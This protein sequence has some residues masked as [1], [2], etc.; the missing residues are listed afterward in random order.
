MAH[1]NLP[2]GH[3]ATLRGERLPVVGKRSHRGRRILLTFGALVLVVGILYLA[4]GAYIALK[5]SA[6]DPMA[7]RAGPQVFSLAYES[8]A[9]KARDGISL[10]SW[11]M[12]REGSDRAL[13][14]VHGLWTCRSCEFD[15]RFVELASHLHDAGYNIL[16]I[17]LRK[18]GQSGG[19]HVTYGQNE[20]LDVLAAVDWLKQRGFN[21]IGVVGVS[22]GGGSAV[23]AAAD[24]QGGDSIHALVLDSVFSNWVETMD[25]SFTVETGLPSQLLPGAILMMRVLM[26]VDLYAIRPVDKLPNIKAPVMMIYGGQDKYLTRAQMDAMHQARPDAEFWFVPEAGHTRIYNIREQEYVTRVTRF[27]DSALR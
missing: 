6:P 24:P 7:A 18:H 17:D 11:F 5:L 16:M 2:I 9:I 21:K 15:G 25:R 14:L 19:E 4:I 20:R 1:I 10:A 12:P 27:L 26:N 3:T 13:L 8:P 22:L 23:M